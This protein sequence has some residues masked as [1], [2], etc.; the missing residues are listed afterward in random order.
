MHD[1]ATDSTNIKPAYNQEHLDSTRPTYLDTQP[2]N[3]SPKF[4]AASFNV[5]GDTT[6][7]KIP[8]NRTQQESLE[9]W[10]SSMEQAFN[11]LERLRE[12]KLIVDTFLDSICAQSTQW[13]WKLVVYK[14]LEDVHR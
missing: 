7:L 1:H 14:R 10:I 9:E 11:V 13:S 5:D 6:S 4:K 8:E 3:S 12:E 2:E